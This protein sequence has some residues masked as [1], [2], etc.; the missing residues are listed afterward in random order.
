MSDYGT[1]AGVALI[2]RKYANSSQAFDGSTV[3][4]LT[5]VNTW[6]DEVCAELNA[7]LADARFT[8]PITATAVTPML[9]RFVNAQVARMVEA[10][11]L[12]HRAGP[13]VSGARNNAVTVN[14]V[15][16]AIPAAVDAFVRQRAG[17]IE[18]MGA[19]RGTTQITVGSVAMIRTDAYSDDIDSWE[20]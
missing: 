3:P 7:S 17:G 13:V 4:T 10:L 8:I 9:D 20:T 19:G 6:L 14:D 2:A 15:L 5:Q 11:H 18:A 1:A 12:S 16:A